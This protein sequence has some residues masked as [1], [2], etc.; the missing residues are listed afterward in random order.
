MLPT[1]GRSS[2]HFAAPVNGVEPKK[3][4]KQQHE[5][6]DR[7]AEGGGLANDVQHPR[8]KEKETRQRHTMRRHE[9]HGSLKYDWQGVKVAG[10]ICLPNKPSLGAHKGIPYC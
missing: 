3:R 6:A 7:G 5:V 9:R 2:L 8:R 4:Q 10:S 1:R